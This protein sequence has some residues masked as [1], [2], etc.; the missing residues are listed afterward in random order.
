LKFEHL[1][2]D[3]V[4]FVRTVPISADLAQKKLTVLMDR[5]VEATARAGYEMVQ[6]SAGTTI[7]VERRYAAVVVDKRRATLAGLE[8]LL[9]TLDVA[10]LDQMKVDPDVRAERVQLVLAHTAF[11][12]A[13]SRT[14]ASGTT[15]Q[16]MKASR[17]SA[18]DYPVVVLV[19]YGNQPDEFEAGLA[20][21]HEFL[22]RIEIDSKRGFTTELP[23]T[24]SPS[25]AEGDPEAE[26]DP[27]F[28]A[29]AE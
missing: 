15:A 24:E 11:R 20:E 25:E 28:E 10:N 4:L 22:G 12:Y 27:T 18:E 7:M 19:G 26:S 14:T 5:Y 3:G 2:H 9:I 6:F 17:T 29:A 8:A 21:F 16:G 23:S 13:P 1:V